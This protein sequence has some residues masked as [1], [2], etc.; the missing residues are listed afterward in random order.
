MIIKF[1]LLIFAS[2]ILP[3]FAKFSIQNRDT[4]CDAQ[5]CDDSDDL[6]QDCLG[7][8]YDYCIC[9]L[10][11][12]FWT[13]FL[14]CAQDCD[15]QYISL[16]SPETLKQDYCVNIQYS[17]YLSASESEASLLSADSE[18]PDSFETADATEGVSSDFETVFSTIS[19]LSKSQAKSSVRSN[20]G[21]AGPTTLA[22][23]PRST[24]SLANSS[25]STT[26]LANSPRSTTS[27]A[28]SPRSTTTS[29]NSSRSTP[30]QGN[31]P[32]QGSSPSQGNSPN[33]GSSPSQGNSPNQGGS[34]IQSSPSQGSSSP[35]S[36]GSN[37]GS[38]AVNDG[39]VVK[40]GIWS[41]LFLLF[42]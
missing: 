13:A 4:Y 39:V 3:I 40:A 31:S 8:Y 38:G 18:Y 28:T 7:P 29:A 9:G 17:V 23:S 15:V 22:N 14:K 26:T 19:Q 24:T 12:D 33:Q 27:L 1:Q 11:I 32:N 20:G 37:D 35:S 36:R 34:F 2:L 30:S 10:G 21:I 25:R 6:S 42:L 16:Y 41:I 5:S